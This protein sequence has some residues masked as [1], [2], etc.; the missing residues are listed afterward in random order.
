MPVYTRAM[1]YF[2]Q[3]W[4]WTAT[5][6]C[7]IAISVGVGLLEAWPFAVLVDSVLTQQPRGDWIHGVFLSLLPESKTGQ[8][9]GLV[10]IGLALQVIGATAWMARMMINYHLNYRG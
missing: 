7:L 2:A 10:L 9:V 4:R 3:D 1:A 6:V 8:I 5:L